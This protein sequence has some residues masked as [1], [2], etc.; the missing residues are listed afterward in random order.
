M[1]FDYRDFSC[2]IKPKR[3]CIMNAHEETYPVTKVGIVEITFLFSLPYMLLVL[4]LSNKLIYV[5]QVTT[6]LNYVVL[7]YP[8]F[9]LI[10]DINTKEIIGCSTKKEGLYLHG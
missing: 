10:Q 2:I 3:T 8:T 6:D 5:S 9:C 4:S 7:M 1:M